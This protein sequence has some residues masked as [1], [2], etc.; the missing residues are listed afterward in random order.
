MDKLIFRKKIKKQLFEYNRLNLSE[1]SILFLILI[2]PILFL[3]S[4]NLSNMVPFVLLTEMLVYF[5]INRKLPI[6]LLIKLV[7]LI[8]IVFTFSIF[9]ATISLLHP[10]LLLIFTIFW[11]GIYA[12]SMFFGRLTRIFGL[13]SILYF[14]IVSLNLTTLNLNTFQLWVLSVLSSIL[15]G[16][17]IVLINYLKNDPAICTAVAKCFKLNS[18]LSEISYVEE[19]ASE[20]SNNKLISLIEI[21]KD[22]K[23]SRL[24][25]DKIKSNL[26]LDVL[27][28]F[29]DILQEIDKLTYKINH[30]LAKNNSNFNISL[31]KFKSKLNFLYRFQEQD[32]D[33]TE[34][35]NKSEELLDIF[36]RA[37]NILK[38]EFNEEYILPNLTSNIYVIDII[39]ANFNID[40]IYIQNYI[41]FIVAS[42]LSLLILILTNNYNMHNLLFAI[43]L[44]FLII[45]P[46]I[47]DNSLMFSQMLSMLF[48]ICISLGLSL[49]SPVWSLLLVVIL[50]CLSPSF[51]NNIII[52]DFIF[53]TILLSIQINTITITN[54][55]NYVFIY[56]IVCLTSLFVKLILYPHT[57]KINLYDSLS[58]KIKTNFDFIF[59]VLLSQNLHDYSKYWMKV[60]Q[61]NNEFEFALNTFIR[62]YSTDNKLILSYRDVSDSVNMLTLKSLAFNTHVNY[63]K[64][65]PLEKSLNLIKKD[66]D[67]IV[68]NLDGH[69]KITNNTKFENIYC[70]I[71]KFKKNCEDKNSI[72]ALEYLLWIVYDL[73]VLSIFLDDLRLN[74]GF[75]E[76]MFIY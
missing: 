56:L 35:V 58:F 1:I 57:S 27:I 41:R 10:I 29:E 67:E 2:I 22:I 32:T 26:D 39:K 36:Q 31:K 44:V 8:T 70:K 14:L 72:L 20:F 21:S 6:E 52:K 12:L 24:N 68:F 50:L 11:S 76:D 23:I 47:H 62:E 54:C 51:K 60:S 65:E 43:I 53:V 7:F 18:S 3:F 40:N 49:Y 64:S 73:Y 59:E 61:K 66:M 55:L 28:V 46:N 45:K 30:N 38:N 33:I 15:S 71:S 75:I 9:S 37:N 63:K 17:T 19:L 69:S 4:F 16:F 5:L 13:L 48:A 74:K 25:V 34:A 42:T